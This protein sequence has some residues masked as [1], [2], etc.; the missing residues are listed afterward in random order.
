MKKHLLIITICLV[1]HCFVSAQTD[2]SVY[3]KRRQI[4][5]DKMEG[6]IAIFPSA[7]NLGSR[8][9]A[10]YEYRQGSDF[11]YLTGFPGSNALILLT[12][13]SED[14]FILFV[15]PQ[16]PGEKR[17]IGDTYGLE[18]A[19]SR[20]GADKAYSIYRV[21]DLLG[22]YLENKKTIFIPS[23]DRELKEM[24]L[25][26]IGGMEADVRPRFVDPLPLV[27]EMRV[28]KD[29]SEIE[30]MKQAIGI[31][32]EALRNA[33]RTCK[34]GM[35]EYEIEAVIEYT[36]R[37]NGAQRPG[38]PS[39]IGSGPNTTILHYGMNSRQMKA[40]DLLLMDIGAE[41]NRYTA[42]VTRTIPVN[43][44]FSKEQQ[45]IYEHNDDG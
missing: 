41:Y 39:I 37:K 13:D 4:F 20:F 43:G 34:P 24:V 1:F 14:Q 9:G 5:L 22:K 19:V 28:F 38:F 21:R 29:P 15:Q 32:C 7:E 18:E 2:Y 40:G 30:T 16:D 10:D 36:F 8:A 12:P 11:Y 6:G 3:E 25:R 23:G 35:K 31:T 27:H 42:D 17:W 44:V 26:I 45:E 33:Y